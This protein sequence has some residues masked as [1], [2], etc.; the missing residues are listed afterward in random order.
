MNAHVD[1]PFDGKTAWEKS[2]LRTRAKYLQYWKLLPSLIKAA[3]NRALYEVYAV[4]ST[5]AA[6]FEVLLAMVL[7]VFR[8]TG[9]LHYVEW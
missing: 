8:S 1:E 4:S 7:Q 2:I 9:L 6:I 5:V 3:Y